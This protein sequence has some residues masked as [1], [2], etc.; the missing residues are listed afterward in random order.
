MVKD[1]ISLDSL[2]NVICEAGDKILPMRNNLNSF[3]I[4]RKNDN[5]LLTN[6][7]LLANDIICSKLKKTKIPILSE[8]R[9]IKL[10]SNL[11]WIIDPIDGTKDYVNNSNEFTV[12]IALICN[13]VPVVGLIY[14]PALNQLF[15]K[16]LDKECF[17]IIDNK[18]ISLSTS[19]NT[20]EIL[21]LKSK[22]EKS[23]FF[24]K[25]KKN[26]NIVKE[27]SVSSSLKFGKLF[28]NEFT[29]YLRT[30]GSSEWDVAAGHALLLGIGGNIIDLK[31]K[32]QLKYNKLNFRNSEF[33]AFNSSENPIIKNLNKL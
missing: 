1:I 29:T 28:T 6:A 17:S 2:I 27:A 5:S 20:K 13:G 32:S 31:T 9:I 11:Y 14:A 8:E 26:Y 10:N 23:N 16:Y 24:N 25:I 30:V 15:V 19:I 4:S 21:L 7:D 12:N 3:Q 18:K 22:S 33:L